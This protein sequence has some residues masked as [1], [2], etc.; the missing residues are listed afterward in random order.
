MPIS[1]W[2]VTCL[3]KNRFQICVIIVQIRPTLQSFKNWPNHNVDNMWVDKKFIELK[4]QSLSALVHNALNAV[5]HGSSIYTKTTRFAVSTFARP[6]MCLPVQ[7]SKQFVIFLKTIKSKEFTKW[8]H[9]NNDWKNNDS[10]P[11]NQ[12][13]R[14]ID[15]FRLW[16]PCEENIPKRGM[17]IHK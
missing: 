3:L 10:M 5:V 6:P 17:N 4:V 1:N 15:D 7:W 9:W 12:K 13:T 14:K 2:S 8:K 16:S 11:T